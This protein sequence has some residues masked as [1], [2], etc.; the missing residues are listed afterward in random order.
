MLYQCVCG[1]STNLMLKRYRWYQYQCDCGSQVHLYKTS[2]GTMIRKVNE[3]KRTVLHLLCT[4]CNEPIRYPNEGK[5]LEKEF[6]TCP[7]CRQ[8]S[9]ISDELKEY[10][11]YTTTVIDR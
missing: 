1:T 6:I 5:L 8:D 10:I 7:N 11:R 9:T 3:Q 4:V 2:V